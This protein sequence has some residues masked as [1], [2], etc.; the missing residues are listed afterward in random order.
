M[1]SWTLPGKV[2]VKHFAQLLI[3]W[4]GV[5]LQQRHEAISEAG[6]AF[7]GQVSS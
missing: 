2:S 7:V 5:L 1:S 3:G 6:D 4:I